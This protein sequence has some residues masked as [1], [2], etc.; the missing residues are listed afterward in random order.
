MNINLHIER[1]IVDDLPLGE[2]SERQLR[3][4][5]EQ[6]LSRLFTAEG[7]PDS[8]R[9]GGARPRMAGAPLSLSPGTTALGLGQGVAQSIYRSLGQF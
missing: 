9:G 7:L 3:A 4:G 2:G 1:L 6:E 8:L 5:L